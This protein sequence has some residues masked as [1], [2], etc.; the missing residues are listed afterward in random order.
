LIF[1]EV[2]TLDIILGSIYFRISGVYTDRYFN[3]M[4]PVLFVD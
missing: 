4:Y 1:T 3:L 2:V